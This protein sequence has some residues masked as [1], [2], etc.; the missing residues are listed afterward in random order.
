M[1][2]NNLARTHNPQLHQDGIQTDE[3]EEE[4]DNVPGDKDDK[5]VEESETSIP[6]HPLSI[7][8]LGNAY[9]SDRD[10]RTASGLFYW[11]PEETLMYILEQLDAESLV[12]L[13]ATCKAL[14][15]FT[16]ADELWKA[17]YVS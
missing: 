2:I 10:L 17:I 1:F 14:Y 5:E 13:G 12:A 7:K 4:I 6:Q 16:R 8:P 3:K 11:L 15:A 9:A